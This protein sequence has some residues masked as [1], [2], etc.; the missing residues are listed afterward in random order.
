MLTIWNPNSSSRLTSP[1]NNM[2]K[3]EPPHQADLFHF[4]NQIQYKGVSLVC[5]DKTKLKIIKTGIDKAVQA[6][7][8][9][10]GLKIYSSPSHDHKLLPKS[11]GDY[12][13]SK[14]EIIYR[15]G[16]DWSQLATQTKIDF[17]VWAKNTYAG[18]EEHLILHEIGHYLH[19]K[20]DGEDF[21]DSFD[22]T[23][24]LNDQKHIME[25][26]GH[27][28]PAKNAG[29]LIAEMFAGKVGGNKEFSSYINFIYKAYNGPSISKVSHF[30]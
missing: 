18:G 10:D 20:I 21:C 28:Y 16:I 29:E 30:I 11:F 24:D 13:P 26:L 5:S 14:K 17:P 22:Q 2:P 8:D 4:T 9:L 6:G 19:H 1:K 23:F 7:F 15:Y 27:P 12:F 3:N 25:E